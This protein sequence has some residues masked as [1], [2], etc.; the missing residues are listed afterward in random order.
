MQGHPDQ[1]LAILAQSEV[2]AETPVDVAGR[3][4]TVRDLVARAKS[5][6][7]VGQE[8]CWTIIA[9]S[10]YE[11]T[12]SQW[13]NAYGQ[14]VRL[15]DLVGAEVRVTPSHSPCGGTHNLHGLAYALQ[16]R[17]AEGRDVTGVWEAADGK[18]AQYVERA[19]A[20]QNTDGS[21]STNYFAGGGWSRNA[22]TQMYVTGH[23]LEWLSTYL[24]A[25]ELSQ[26]WV[27]RGVESLLAA[28][29]QTKLQSLDCG[30]LYHGIHGLRLYYERRFGGSAVHEAEATAHLADAHR[31]SGPVQDA[32][33]P[34]G[35][36]N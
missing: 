1:F 24:S 23:T 33:I 11:G 9:L 30:S 5:D 32:N 20:F 35:S 28:L 36:L 15:E 18:L 4:Y 16:R 3:S 21:F 13:T 7:Y 10:Y 22:V 31:P 34:N 29:E 2:P 25:E 17:R 6:A 8:S 27:T 26:P 14:T 12:D 19:R